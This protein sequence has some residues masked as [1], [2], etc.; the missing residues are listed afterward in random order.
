MRKKLRLVEILLFPVSIAVFFAGWL[1]YYFGS[2]KSDCRIKKEIE[3]KNGDS[4]HFGLLNSE[5]QEL[6][7]V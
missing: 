3:Q 4:I 6:L 7:T 1:F 2:N 5:Q